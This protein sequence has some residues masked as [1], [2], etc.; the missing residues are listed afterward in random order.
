MVAH[1]KGDDY[2]GHLFNINWLTFT[3]EAP[4]TTD[5]ILSINCGGPREDGMPP[6][7]MF[8]EGLWGYEGDTLV[9]ATRTRD[10]I[11]PNCSLPNALQ[12]ARCAAQEG[13]S[14]HYRFVVANGLYKVQLFFAETEALSYNVRLFDVAVNEN[15]VLTDFDVFLAAGGGRYRGVMKEIPANV[16]N[17]QI[18][19]KFISK[20][21]NAMI[22]AIKILRAP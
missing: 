7:R 22:S 13:G 1:G 21:G 6:D 16:T 11:Y 5:P 12:T 10:I 8:T 14:F 18:D 4:P 15:V 2:A 20:H 3:R 19:L 17:G 9:S